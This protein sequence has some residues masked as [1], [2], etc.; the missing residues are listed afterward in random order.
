MEGKILTITVPAYNVESYI[1][2]CLDSFVINQILSDIEVIIVNDGSTDNTV[3]IAE[4]YVQKYPDTFKIVT[5]QNG[6]H[7]STINV[8]INLA[9]GKYFK[10]I[11]GD[12]Y[13]NRDGFISLVEKLK[14]LQSDLVLTNYYWID[15]TTKK[16][17]KKVTS[18]WKSAE[19]EK[20]YIF[21]EIC[22]DLFLRMHGITVKTE[23][24]R[25][26][27]IKIDENKF[28][29]DQEYVLYLT[30]HIKTVTVINAD[31][32]MYRLGING[33][34]MNIKSMQKNVDQHY[35]VLTTLL[36]YYKDLQ[37]WNLEKSRLEFLSKGLAAM[38][39][40][41]IKIYL[42]FPM[43]KEYKKQIM[44]LDHMLKKDYPKVYK[45]IKQPAIKILRITKYT[46]YQFGVMGMKIR[47]H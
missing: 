23:I 1:K 41:Q 13:V 8:G 30:P 22:K 34:S 28:Y 3:L 6:G 31:V 42:S 14:T 25:D 40:S 37:K 32:Y 19:Y 7:G 43:S 36:K 21:T 20:E 38:V 11:D 10:V 4:E 16:V 12:D 44:K 29:V 35:E 33:Q 47:G 18:T 39:G 46:F 27:N 45:S 26:N 15:H 2:E 24:Y 17:H 9:K 5:K